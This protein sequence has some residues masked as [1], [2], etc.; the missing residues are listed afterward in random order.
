[1]QD[2][3]HKL[4]VEKQ[5][6][7]WVD[8]E[9]NSP[10]TLQYL[11]EN[12]EKVARSRRA[13]FEGALMQL[14]EALQAGTYAET[15]VKMLWA[16]K[17]LSRHIRGRHWTTRRNYLREHSRTSGERCRGAQRRTEQLA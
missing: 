17:Q 11:W 10:A 14:G 6:R 5:A 12:G 8:P 2:P 15:L 13:D 16:R 7:K 4:A 1:M 9:I 3:W